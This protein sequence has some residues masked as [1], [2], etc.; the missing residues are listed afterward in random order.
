MS[1]AKIRRL[2]ESR[3]KTWADAR[4]TPLVVAWQNAPL[5]EH[6]P[7]Y[8]QAFLLP[9]F[10]DSQDMKGDHRSYTGVFQISIVCKVGQG[11]GEGEGIADELAALY[12]L[13][14]RLTLSDFTV[15]I[16][17]P[18]AISPAI[19]ESDRYTVPV[20]FTYRADTV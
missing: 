16:I 6:D 13:N 14:L 19:P 7:T 20:S 2:Y 4:S 8:L 12:P 18:L 17:T 11:S 1:Q 10:T 15:Q 5:K 9:A 3:L